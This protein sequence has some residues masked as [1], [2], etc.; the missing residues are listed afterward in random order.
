MNMLSPIVHLSVPNKYSINGYE[1]HV[2][3]SDDMLNAVYKLRHEVYSEELNWVPSSQDGL[4]IDSFDSYSTHFS[5]T[6]PC[7]RVVAT[8]RTVLPEKY[9]F[10]DEYFQNTLIDNTSVI[11]E[12]GAVEASR[13]AISHEYRQ[14]PLN[15]EGATALD[16]LQAR[17]I[18][19]TLDQQGHEYTLITT[20]P[21]M[22]LVLKRRGVA[23]KQHGPIITM[24]DG[25]K[26]A[27][28]L[29]DLVVTRDTYRSYKQIMKLI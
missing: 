28:Y 14:K 15:E 2:V 1:A 9:W 3:K 24:D 10:V 26:V 16:L 19:Y 11:K 7:G 8:I 12:Q 13:L 18:D 29:C 17:L 27:T 6:D 22:G 4:E 23:I 21:F 5:V 25:C 20:T